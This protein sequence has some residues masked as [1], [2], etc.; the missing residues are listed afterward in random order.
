V[1][2]LAALAAANGQ[3]R[4]ASVSWATD[5]SGQWSNGLNWSSIPNPPSSADNVVIDRTG[6]D[7]TITVSVPESA[8][9][10]TLFN[11]LAISGQLSLATA[12]QS[13]GTTTIGAGGQL[14][15]ANG[16]TFTNPAGATLALESSGT[17]T[18]TSG[19]ATINNAG[20]FRV[21]DNG[22]S[23]S[24]GLGSGL[25]FNNTGSF[26]LGTTGETATPYL[27]FQG[28]AFNN[29]GSVSVQAGNLYLQ[30][31]GTHTGSF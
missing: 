15:L 11:T 22:S 10:L 31:G 24:N 17:I 28:T 2:M 29:S 19:S 16:A 27:Y 23:Y 8:N 20:A 6:V 13:N 18:T 21:A 7:P 26:A 30:A 25:T 14:Q 1:A 5:S 4:A 12:S 3:L 9:S